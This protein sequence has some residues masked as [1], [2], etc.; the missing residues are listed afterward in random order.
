MRPHSA[1]T[2]RGLTSIEALCVLAAAGT[3]IL[4]PVKPATIFYQ[5]FEKLVFSWYVL[6]NDGERR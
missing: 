5:S 1:E 3:N 4:K 2:T 6:L